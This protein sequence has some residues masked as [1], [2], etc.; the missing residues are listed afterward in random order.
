[1]LVSFGGGGLGKSGN[2]APIP[3]QRQGSSAF[4]LSATATLSSSS[5]ALP[6]WAGSITLSSLNRSAAY[7]QYVDIIPYLS[8]P[9]NLVT[10]EAIYPADPLQVSAVVQK[11]DAQNSPIGYGPANDPQ[12]VFFGRSDLE[13]GDLWAVFAQP[14]GATV[15][16]KVGG[17]WSAVGPSGAYTF[18]WWLWDNSLQ[19]FTFGSKS[20][21]M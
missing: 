3:V 6:S 18:W 17:G 21:S 2:P 12:G 16:A 4:T 13:N 14:S 5:S 11:F 15:T 7:P 20:F 1:M 19:T 9:G 10:S 8:D